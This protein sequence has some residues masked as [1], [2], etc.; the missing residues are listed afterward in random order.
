MIQDL[1][2][3]NLDRRLNL[4]STDE[5]GVMGRAMDDFAD[6]LRDE[7]LG[8]FNSLA[9]GDFTFR[10]KGLIREPLERANASM[11]ELLT[12]IQT[13]GE[14]IASGSAQISDSSQA[15]SQGA[16]ESSA[17]LQQITATM[18]VMDGQTRQAA[19]SAGQADH[20]ATRAKTAA[21]K[22]NERMQQ[23]MDAIAEISASG[24]N[25]SKIIK[26]IDEIAF[27]TNLLALNA[28]VEAARAGQHGKGFAV[29]AEEVRNLAA[30]SAKAAQETSDLIEGS[31]QKTRNGTEIA[32][33]TEKALKEIVDGIV[34]ATD[35]VKGIAAAAGEQVEKIGQVCIGLEQIDSVT[36][37]NTA[38]TEE[39]AAAA[40]ELASQADA[41]R[42]ML[43]RFRID[44]ALP[45]GSGLDAFQLLP[46]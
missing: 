19:E 44:S 14:Q 26:T 15:L 12:R 6:N 28:A 21:E 22:G 36:Q 24:Q 42:Q 31:V 43:S 25:I 23:M 9:E 3:G 4:D 29:V 11:C 40:E 35:L 17:S 32:G 13:A 2:T 38:S 1:A 37:Q 8:A 27:Q 5:F 33:E 7:V 16:T 46:E 41:L 30:R 20:L 45:Q 18:S 39:S 34:S 10:A